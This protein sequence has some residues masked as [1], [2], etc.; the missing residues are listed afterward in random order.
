M[1]KRVLADRS[2]FKSGRVK[3]S[4]QAAAQSG[5]LMKYCLPAPCH[6]SRGQSDRPPKKHSGGSEVQKPR[7]GTKV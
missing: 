3:G 2:A 7:S 1:A 4:C 5:G 6:D